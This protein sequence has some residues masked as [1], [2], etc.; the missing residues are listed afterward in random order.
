MK[1]NNMIIPK[2]K[3]WRSGSDG[4]QQ[5]YDCWIKSHVRCNL[6]GELLQESHSLMGAG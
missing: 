2:M 1:K 5:S 6:Q 4:A 3:M